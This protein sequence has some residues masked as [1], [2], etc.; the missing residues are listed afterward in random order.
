MAVFS[1]GLSWADAAGRGLGTRHVR[2]EAAAVDA[3]G[4]VVVARTLPAHRGIS[5][6]GFRRDRTIDP[7]FGA[8]GRV[9]LSTRQRVE[10][11]GVAIQ[12]DGRIVMVGALLKRAAFHP[13]T[14]YVRYADHGTIAWR[15]RG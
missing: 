12:P 3:E 15:V 1:G 2:V 14:G 8:H 13:G 6:L 5:L 9:H 11:R 7:T 4:R 10:A